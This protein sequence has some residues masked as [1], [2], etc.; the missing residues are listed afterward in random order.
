MVFIERSTKRDTE[1]SDAVIFTILEESGLNILTDSTGTFIQ[2]SKYWTMVEETTK[3][4]S[5][6]LT[7][8]QYIIPFINTAETSFS[9]D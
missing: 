8:R 9:L 5:L 7:P 3:G 1:E 4:N 2:D 6:F